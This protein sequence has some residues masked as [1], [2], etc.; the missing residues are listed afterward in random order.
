MRLNEAP[1]SN[2]F[3][4]KSGQKRIF[5]KCHEVFCVANSLINFIDCERLNL[6]F[7]YSEMIEKLLL[8]RGEI[9]CIP[10]PG[11]P[12]PGYFPAGNGAAVPL[13]AEMGSVTKNRPGC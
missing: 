5:V 4:P 13:E 7:Y 1:V 6:H 11:P 8:P 3:R 2:E 9:S 12:T 10:P